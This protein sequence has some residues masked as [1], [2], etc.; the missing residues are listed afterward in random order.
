[1]A[2]FSIPE[3][4]EYARTHPRP[5]IAVAHS[6]MGPGDATW[7]LDMWAVELIEYARKLG[8]PVIDIGG[9]DLIY[10]RMTSI[11]HATKPAI[12]F[13]FSHGCRTYLMGNDMKCTL[14]RG[15]EDA[16]SCGVCGMP[17]NLN[18]ISGT[19][20]IAYSCHSGAQLSKCAIQY[21][22]PAYVGFSDSLIIVSDNYGT[23]NIYKEALLPIARH[24]LEN[25]TIGE[26]VQQARSDLLS[27][28]KLYK[29]VELISVPLYYNRK[30]LVQEGN[31]NWRL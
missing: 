11:L 13:N 25:W 22:A 19:A 29:P 3:L 12:L 23:Q 24:V 8:Y 27:T 5:T 10:E 1:M 30:Y 6:N 31:P 28:V 20:I 26:A 7:H 2:L 15:W 17:S 9:H 18:A 14:T 4:R 16:E 21:G